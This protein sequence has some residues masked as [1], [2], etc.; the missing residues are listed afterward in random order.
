MS[1]A[2]DRNLAEYQKNVFL[3]PFDHFTFKTIPCLL[4]GIVPTPSV[5]PKGLFEFPKMDFC[6]AV[7]QSADIVILEHESSIFRLFIQPALHVVLEVL[8]KFS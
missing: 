1:T 4:P 5:S 2:Q 8:S 3:Q 6:G 7:S